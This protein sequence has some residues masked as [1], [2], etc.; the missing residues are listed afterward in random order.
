ML[1]PPG[2]ALYYVSTIIDNYYPRYMVY[3]FIYNKL[4]WRQSLINKSFLQQC[5]C[6]SVEGTCQ[7]RTEMALTAT[8]PLATHPLTLTFGQQ[9]WFRVQPPIPHSPSIVQSPLSYGSP[10]PRSS[11]GTGSP[12]RDLAEISSPYQLF[13]IFHSEG[14]L[15]HSILWLMQILARL[16]YYGL[17]SRSCNWLSA[18]GF[19]CGLYFRSG[20]QVLSVLQPS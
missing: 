19:Q 10:P 18:L 1:P 9:S 20:A 12:V 6:V 4:E 11:I 14:I 7:K 5:N 8:S 15:S 16:F 13:L 17:S 3:I 2:S